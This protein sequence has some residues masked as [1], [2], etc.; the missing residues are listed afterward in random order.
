[1][2]VYSEQHGLW[3]FLLYGERIRNFDVPDL[4]GDNSYGLQ[5]PDGIPKDFPMDIPMTLYLR[6]CGN[7]K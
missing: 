4:K 5:I 1:M 2:L 7:P 3:C 6:G